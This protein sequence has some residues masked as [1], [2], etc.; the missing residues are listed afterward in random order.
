MNVDG[1]NKQPLTTSSKSFTNAVISPD[2][3]KIAALISGS[4]CSCSE[5]AVMNID[6]TGLQQITFGGGLCQSPAW[7]PDSKMLAYT[8]RSAVN[9]IHTYTINADGSGNKKLNTAALNDDFSMWSRDGKYIIHQGPK[10]ITQAGAGESYIWITR[11][12]GLS[13][14]SIKTGESLHIFPVFIEN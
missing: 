5:I 10:V 7:S 3:K 2:G 1:S 4:S 13:E 11:A 8:A 9:G 12:D 14:I 6:G